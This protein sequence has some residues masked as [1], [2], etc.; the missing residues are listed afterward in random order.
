MKWAKKEGYLDMQ[1]LRVFIVADTISEVPVELEDTTWTNIHAETVVG[2]SVNG[3]MI[4]F[5]SPT[6]I[7]PGDKLTVEF[8][9]RFTVE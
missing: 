7:A 9:G 2:I 5:D 8:D 3:R 4:P 6:V 1:T